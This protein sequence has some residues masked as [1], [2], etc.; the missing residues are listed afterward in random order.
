MRRAA[1]FL[2]YRLL[3]GT[4]GE[5]KAILDTQ[6]DLVDHILRQATEDRDDIVKG[7]A[8]AALTL[9]SSY[10]SPLRLIEEQSCLFV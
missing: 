7:H 1:V 9:L 10:R 5:L 2:L 3:E 6:V 8:E 4:Q